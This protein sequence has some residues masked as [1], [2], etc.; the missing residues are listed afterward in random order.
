MSLAVGDRV[1]RYDVTAHIGAGAMGEVYRARDA[2]LGRDVAIK[3]LPGA[4]AA[5]PERLERFQRE[6]Q[7]LASLN[8]P[9][10]ATIYGLEDVG[11]GRALVLELVEGP[12]LAEHMAAGPCPIEDAL[13]LAAQMAEALDAAHR[14]GVVHR[15]L[16]PANIKVRPDGTVKV[17]DFGLAK[18]VDQEEADDVQ[19]IADAAQAGMIV[20]T[21]AYM[22]PEQ[23]R[24]RPVDRRADIWAFG[25][26]LYELLVG[27]RLFTGDA[28]T[29]VIAEV[30]KT[31][32]DFSA[33]PADT[34]PSIR[35]LLR[36]CLEKGQAV[37]L[38]DIG[39]ARLEIADAGEDPVTPTPATASSGDGVSRLTAAAAVLLTGAIVGAAAWQLA[40]PSEPPPA[41]FSLSTG[42]DTPPFVAAVSADLAVAPDGSRVAFLTEQDGQRALQL[43]TLDALTPTTVVDSGSPFNPFFSPDGEWLGYYD[44]SGPVLQRVSLS[45]GAVVTITELPGNLA[46]ATWAENDEIVFATTDQGGGLWSVSA[47]G[48]TP[49]RLTAPATADGE[50]DHR[51]PSVLPD[52]AGVLFTI[53]RGGATT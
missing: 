9:G 27:C 31:A 41:W 11:D 47:D 33:L 44:S 7:L 4:F 17:L 5:D 14:A 24:G 43:R 28:V 45:T 53:T 51:F 42:L 22:S 15:D 40:R 13:P 26:I 23:A 8:H 34:P 36:R 16:K 35:R 39:V 18:A 25:V 12:T 30:L 38:P 52:N 3:V 49:T 32:P 21:P 19:T 1:G 48:D 20:G 37:R 29:Q 46:G 2:E 10:I 50:V 6:A